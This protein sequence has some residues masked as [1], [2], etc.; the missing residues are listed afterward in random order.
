M[1]WLL[2][3]GGLLAMSYV[4]M[5]EFSARRPQPMTT[6][7]AFTLLETHATVG[8]CACLPQ[9]DMTLDAMLAHLRA[10]PMDDAMRRAALRHVAAC[11]E[12][13]MADLL[14]RSSA[15][16]V[17]T[18][19]LREA[20]QGKPDVAQRLGLSGPA[21]LAEQAA[22][23]LVDLR[24]ARGPEADVHRKWAMAFQANITDHAPLEDI[25][26]Q[27][28]D[29]PYSAEAVKAA[30]DDFVHVADV[31]EALAL[32][33]AKERYPS[34]AETARRAE[35]ALER[36][37]VSLGAQARHMD[38][39]SPVGL[40]RG[41][42]TSISVRNG[43]LDYTVSGQ[44]MSY[45]RGVAFDAAQAALLM[46][47]VE[48]YSSWVSVDGLGLPDCASGRELVRARRS[49]LLEQGSAALDPNDLPL[50]AA[51]SN[52]PLHWLPCENAG[53][54]TVHVPAQFIALFANLDEQGF[55]GGLGS[56][57][58]ASGNTMQQARL[59]AL[60]EII[61]R[62]A[63]T[64]TPVDPRTWMRVRSDDKDV[65]ALLAKYTRR[66]V[67][68]LL[69]ECTSELGIPCYKA[70]AI[71]PQGQVVKGASAKLSGA[72]AALSAILEVPYPFPFGP[73]STPGPEDLPVVTLES[74]P[75]MSTGSIATDLKL[76]EE[77]LIRSGRTPVYADLT[78][79]DLALPVTRAIVPRMELLPDFDSYSHVSPRLFRRFLA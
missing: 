45:G 40:V 56:T 38:S 73:P 29:L 42:E 65:A 72:R 20:V 18:G 70:F 59:G 12:A 62:D 76:V 35:A 5:M 34:A 16:P 54:G 47:I 21:T 63:E 49:E 52:E 3:H 8:F 31:R 50:E 1:R 28:L 22:S 36:A 26:Q 39:L 33:P 23:P 6:E 15:D 75:D 2:F 71:G 53:G 7:Y 55:Y 79:K 25:R 41:W 13:E 60:L 51:Y 64:T 14:E 58:L 9:E 10:A 37:G 32:R 11:D 43:A 30:G 61:E 17:V 57:G 78:H 66:G 74:L 69:Q 67:D 27:G 24:A 44:H 4:P 19:L 77:T 68:V 46:E 48:R